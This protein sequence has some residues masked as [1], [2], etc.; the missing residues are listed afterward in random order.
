MNKKL[1]LL[2]LI[3]FYFLYLSSA[4]AQPTQLQTTSTLTPPA[5]V[6][7]QEQQT[8]VVGLFIGKTDPNSMFGND[9]FIAFTSTGTTV[10]LL[11]H[12]KGKILSID[13]QGTL[14]ESFTD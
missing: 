11:V 2:Q 4:Q 10:V 3:L 6:T 8:E 9:P 13:Q 12:T 5:A 14:L 7:N 1:F